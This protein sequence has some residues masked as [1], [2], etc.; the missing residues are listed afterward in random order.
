MAIALSMR[1]MTRRVV[2]QEA[3]ELRPAQVQHAQ[4]ARRDD[5]GDR[6]LAEQDRHLTEEVALAQAG[7]L[8]AVDAHRDLAVEDHVEAGAGEALAQDALAGR[9]TTPRSSCAPPPPPAAASGR[10]TAPGPTACRPAPAGSWP[11]CLAAWLP[12][13]CCVARGRTRPTRP[14]IRFRE[15][16]G[17]FSSSAS[18]SHDATA[19]T[20]VA[21][22]AWT[23][24]LRGC[25]SMTDSSPKNS[26]VPERGEQLVRA[27][28]DVDRAARR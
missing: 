16:A 2:A 3:L 10:R 28:D 19:S 8:V 12:R 9:D 25:W 17:S 24:A 5:V 26:P 7:D 23:L 18:R 14:L 27:T 13:P 11:S 22:A 20:V 21:S 15:S 6:R 4:L 1:S